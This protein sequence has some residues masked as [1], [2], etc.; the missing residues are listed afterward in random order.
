MGIKA[1]DCAFNVSRV[2]ITAK[3]NYPFA[4]EPIVMVFGADPCFF[5]SSPF[6]AW[7]RCFTII[8]NALGL[9]AALLG[10]PA[11]RA[12]PLG[13]GA[14]L[15]GRLAALDVPVLLLIPLRCFVLEPTWCSCAL[16]L[17]LLFAG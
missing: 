7:S 16:I 4:F 15:L 13:L 9:G 3:T 14:A 6:L 17:A 12:V 11:A 1:N 10:R 8:R 2:D 5:W